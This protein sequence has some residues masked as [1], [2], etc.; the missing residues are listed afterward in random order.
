MLVGLAAMTKVPGFFWRFSAH[1]SG[2]DVESLMEAAAMCQQS[3]YTEVREKT[4]RYVISNIDKYLLTQREHSKSC[5]ARIKEI[6]AKHCFIVGGRRQGN[7]LTVAYLT[8][9]LCYLGNIVGQLFLLD[10]FLGNEYHLFGYQ[11]SDTSDLVYVYFVISS[12]V[13][14]L[15]ITC[16]TCD[17][18]LLD[19]QAAGDWRRLGGDRALPTGDTVQ[20]PDQAP[21]EGTRLR[22]SVRAHH[23]LVQRENLYHNLVLVRHSQRGDAS[24]H[25]TV[26]EAGILLARS[27]TL[28]QGQIARLR[29]HE[30][31]KRQRAEVRSDVPQA[32]WA[33]HHSPHRQ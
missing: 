21:G 20:L 15:V 30:E 25:A 13:D 2:I 23:Q 26:D 18:V 33:L 17:I 6:I 9:K 12:F 28:R 4:L 1:H 27:D 32:G 5:Y 31:T 7:Y 11:V 3:S 22:R 19:C 10:R 16:V 14:C 8:V 29:N 24:Q